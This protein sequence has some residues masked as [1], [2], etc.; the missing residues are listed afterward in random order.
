MYNKGLN[1]PKYKDQ[2]GHMVQPSNQER[3]YCKEYGLRE[4]YIIP[5]RSGTKYNTKT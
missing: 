5:D 3:E 1:S 4:W 2:V